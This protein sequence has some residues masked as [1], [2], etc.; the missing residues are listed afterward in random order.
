MQDSNSGS[1]TQRAVKEYIE[2]VKVISSTYKELALFFG[3]STNPYQHWSPLYLTPWM[4][5]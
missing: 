1:Q 3:F 4:A 2:M 5:R